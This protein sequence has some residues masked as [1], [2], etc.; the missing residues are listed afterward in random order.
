ME[1][2]LIINY[3]PNYFNG[4]FCLE[5]SE[6]MNGDGSFKIISQK[7]YIEFF[8][9]PS[10]LER[11]QYILTQYPNVSYCITNHEGSVQV[12]NW[13]SRQPITLSWGLFPRYRRNHQKL[14]SPSSSKYI[15]YFFFSL[16][17]FLT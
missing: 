10:H 1:G 16:Y 3:M 12:T 5:R 17:F 15:Y 9:K 6:G 2:L 8:L 14:S 13:P 4:G 11:L 7:E